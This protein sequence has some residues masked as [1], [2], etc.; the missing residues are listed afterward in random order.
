[1]RSA[2]R[3]RPQPTMGARTRPVASVR[4]RVP[5][6]EFDPLDLDLSVSARANVLVVGPPALVAALL[7]ELVPHLPHP[8]V[9]RRGDSLGVL[10]PLQKGTLVL[11]DVAGLPADRQEALLRWLGEVGPVQ[12]VS[13]DGSPLFP[14]VEAGRFRDD[15]YYHLNTV[16]LDLR[17]TPHV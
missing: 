17:P 3:W 11:E 2:A 1:M 14:L 13:T 10:Q 12:V 7:A 9:R 16:L 6:I 8:V 5:S 4:P 15:L